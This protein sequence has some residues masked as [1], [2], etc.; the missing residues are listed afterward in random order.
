MKS[1]SLVIFIALGILYSQDMN[2]Q[3]P[4]PA[5]KVIELL[6]NKRCDQA[7]KMISRVE[8]LNER[9]KAGGTMLMYSSVNGCREVAD[10]LL[11][12]G[13]L[14]NLK[15]NEG[16]TALHMASRKIGRASCRERV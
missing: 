14:V 4:V 11:D 10:W 16:F 15:S 9:D 7:Y 5:R 13:A 8:D 12:K 2:G 1:H 6:K 3:E